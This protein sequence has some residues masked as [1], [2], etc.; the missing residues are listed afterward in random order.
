ML[1]SFLHTRL[2]KSEIFANIQ[3]G[4]SPP[5]PPPPPSSSSFFRLGYD[6]TIKQIFLI[7]VFIVLPQ[8]LQLTDDSAS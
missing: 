7:G 5:P 8:F 1:K 2:A 3:Q 6:L 4:L